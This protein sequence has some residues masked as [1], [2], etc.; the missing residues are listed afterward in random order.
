[1]GCDRCATPTRSEDAFTLMNGGI[2]CR[3]CLEEWL[4]WRWLAVRMRCWLVKSE[5]LWQMRRKSRG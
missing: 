3:P 1:M 5:S 4:V 2:L